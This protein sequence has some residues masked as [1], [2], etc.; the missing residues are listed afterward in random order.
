M[1]QAQVKLEIKVEVGVQIEAS[2]DCPSGRVGGGLWT[3][4]NKIDTKLKE[5]VH[6]EMKISEQIKLDPNIMMFVFFFSKSVSCPSDINSGPK[7]SLPG[8]ALLLLDLY[9]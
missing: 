5:R 3:D 9:Y 7:M 4:E 6:S 1:G 2:H 8:P